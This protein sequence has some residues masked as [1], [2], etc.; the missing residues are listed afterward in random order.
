GALHMGFWGFLQAKNGGKACTEL[1]GLGGKGEGKEYVK[2]LAEDGLV[3]LE[4]VNPL[5]SREVIGVDK[6]KEWLR[7]TFVGEKLPI[8][9]ILGVNRAPSEIVRIEIGI[10]E[11]G[12]RLLV[13]VEREKED[14]DEFMDQPNPTFS[15]IPILDTGKFEQWKFRIQ[16]YL[17]NEHYAL[18]KVIEFG[19]SYKAPPEETS[20]GPASES[21]T[22]KKGRTVVITIEDM[23]KRRNDVKA[24]TTLLLAL[25]NEHQLR[26]SK[27]ETAQELWEAILN[28]FGGNEATKKTKKNQLKQQY[29]NFKA[30]G[31][32]TLEQTFKRLQ[33]IM[34]H[35]EFMDV[36][37]EQDD[38]NQKF[39]TSLA[40]EW[41]MYTIVWRNR[42]DLDTMSLDDGYNH[43]KVYEPEV[44]KKLE[45]TSQNMAFIS[46]SNTSNGKGEVHTA[47]VPT[48][49]IHVSTVSTDIDK[50]YIEEI[51]IKW[52]MDLLSMR[53]DRFWKKTGKKINIQ[54]SD[55]AGFDKSKVKCFICHKIG[56]FAKECRAPRSQDR[57]KRESYKQGPK[58][59][60]P[61]PKALMALDGIGVI[62]LMR[63]RTMLLKNIKNLNTK[64]SKLNKQL[65]DC[66]TD[67]YHYK[68]GLSQ[69][70]ARLV[71]FKEQEIK[72]CEK[73]RG[74]ERYVEVRNNKNKYLMNELEQVKKEKEGL[75]NKL[76]SFESASK[77]L[78][79]LLGSQRSDK[80]K[81][82]LGYNAVP[83]PH[84]QVYSPPKKDLSW[85][86]LPKFID[87]NVTDYSRPTPSI[88]ESKCN[89]SNNFSISK[90][91]ES[92]G[93]IM[94][95]PMIKFVKAADCPKVTKTNNTENARKSTV[96]HTKM[97][98]NTSKSPKVGGET[99][100]KNNY[101]HKNVTPRAVL[102]KTGRTPLAIS[103][104]NMNVAQPKM[105][106]FAKIAHSNVKRHFQGKSAVRTQP[107]VLRVSTFTKKFPTVDSK[108]PIVKSTFTADL[109]NKGKGNIDDK[110]YWDSGCSRHMTDNIS[111]LSEYE[112]Y[113]GGYVSFGQGG[114][115]I[116]GK[117]I[118]KTGKL[119]F[120]NVYFVKELKYFKLKDDTNVLL[121]TP[122]QHNMYS[123]DLNNI[124]PYKNL[125][126]LVAKASI[127]ESMLWHRRLGHLNFKTMNKLVRNNLV[128]GLPSKCFENDHTC[129][130]CLKGKQHK[131][132][133]KTKLVNFVSKPIHTLHMDLFGPTSAEAVNTACYVK[134]RVLVNKSQNKT[135]YELFNSRIPAIVFL[136]PFGCHVMILNTLDHLGKFDAKEDEG[137]FVGYSMSSKAF[138]V[139]NKRTK[140]VEEN[141]HVDFLENK[142]ITKGVGSNWLFDIDTLT[143][144]MNYVS[145][146]VAG[147]SSTNISGTKDVASQAMKKDV[148]SLRYIALLNWFHDTHMETK[149]SDGC[150]TDDPESSGISNPTTS[151]K[152]PSAEQVEH[153]VSLTVETK[154]PTVSSPVPTVCLDIS[155]ESSS[156]P[157]II[158]KGDFSQKETPSLGNALTLSN[159]F[160]DAFR[161]EADLS[162][163]ETSIPV[164]PTSTFEIHKG[165]PKSQIIGPVDSSVQTRHK[166]KEM[167]EQSFIVTIHHKTN[168]ELLQFCLFLC[169]LSQ[170]EPKKIFDDLKDPSW[171]EGIDYE[172]VFA[173]VVRIKAIRLFLAYAS[174]M[175]FI[176]YQMD[177]KSA[178]LYGTIDEEGEGSTIPTEPHHTPSPQE[179]HSPHHA[180]SSLSH[181]TTTTEPLPQTPTE[182]PTETPTLR[183]YTRRDI[184]IAQSK[185]LSPDADEPASLLR[186]D[187]Q[188]EA[189]PT[190]S[191]LDARQD[192][193]NI[194][195]TSVLPHGSSPR[196]TSLDADEGSMQHRLQKLMELCTSLQ[197]QQ[198]Q[199]AAKIKDQD[200]EI[201]G[202][203]ARVK[204]LEDKDRG[205]AEPTQVD[206]PIKG[207]IME[208]G[209]E[210]RADK[211]TELGSNDTDEMVNV[212]SLMEAANILTSGV[213]AVSVSPVAGVS[214]KGVPTVSGLFPT[215]SAIFTTASVVTPYTRR[216][217]RIL[218][219]DKDKEKVMEFEVPN[220]RKLEEQI[221]AQVAR[222]MKEE[223]TRENQRESEQ[224]T[225]DSEIARLHAEEEIKMMIE[226]LNR[227]N[228]VIAKHLQEYEEAAAEL[229][230]G[231]K[232]ELI[233]ELVKYQDHHTK[234]LK[235][236]AH[237][238]KP[239][240]KK[241]QREFCMSVLRSH[242]GW[243]TKH[244]RGMTLKEIKEKFIPVWKQ[245]EDFVPMSSKEE[246][247]K[248]MM[249]LVPLEEVYVEVLQVKHPIIDWE[250]NS[251]EKREPATK[252]NEKE[253]WVELK[254]LFEPDFEDRLWTHNQ[255]LMHDP[256]EWK[257]YDTYGI[258]HVFFKDQEIF[259]LV[260]KDY[261]LRKG[262][263]TVM[264]CNKLQ[265][266]QYSQMD[267][268]L[269]LKIHNIANSPR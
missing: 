218:A 145:V 87:D 230:V 191:S 207:G 211:S 111:Y 22:K 141:L 30:E 144:S 77:N 2:K 51:D 174:F 98:R 86:G 261:P 43:L 212:L 110:G 250:I 75:D 168:P 157:R 225:R 69:V 117:G 237:Q 108:F 216:S 17:Q 8:N 181:P 54:G 61:A 112:P 142:L 188:R 5:W 189:F 15:K 56:H 58:E 44:Q 140:K 68:R 269:I 28:T 266:E 262:L 104:P 136:R 242:V 194:N 209:E 198:T 34:S 53:A 134:N 135:P 185:A 65:S 130:A 129:V 38:L 210:V 126:C 200:L 72:F 255:A 74:L 199:M 228:E 85:T 238:S 114:G 13:V 42:D 170:E 149:N 265:V 229:S 183:R 36:E 46:S 71:E 241:E 122:R 182:T 220:K 247:L 57:G 37:I 249:Q 226:G 101:A 10:D 41:L 60:E 166:S 217:R 89:T 133:H 6:V 235:Y 124:V 66:E 192:R 48:A 208:T 259:M 260:E 151:S 119:E 137:Y 123:I 9:N 219:K 39:L 40:P 171:E 78:D 16:Q 240:L 227:S 49:S 244:F 4:K 52:N 179:Q 176:V 83:P 11:C 201:F 147:T 263:A 45:L 131:A 254:R 197:R 26:F 155:L 224:L 243:K 62:W 103:R 115:T 214:T 177:V 193:E 55:V 105:T 256:L 164:S 159:R 70:E 138:R 106:S 99:W 196:V 205:S 195:K 257:L 160:K 50:D 156:D 221:D 184:R 121:R 14:C 233:N 32:E 64:I 23:Q 248:G 12:C 132:S 91:R 73:L 125:T 163:M 206:A 90:H 127:N 158:S 18:W 252:D 162:N 251:E 82:G 204:F 35:L 236:H 234:I 128:R 172:E 187:R 143:N 268:D 113:D 25:P 190:V 118:I 180:L 63:K 223:F 81:E 146:V 94:S 95:K 20:K 102:L 116:T 239:L 246:D 222:E 97:Y 178:F 27:Y 120:E 167:E 154:I 169:F 84:A 80:N 29:G 152:V 150:N 79:T 267:N 24:R 148:S 253:L 173:P 139:F 96:K 7:K 67:L 232:I 258:H 47:S 31:S 186:D 153:A 264:I 59:E 76:T 161:E 165:H 100:P 1:G 213:A 109:G 245:L 3:D 202:L 92:L 231:E 33:A 88:D 175:G 203:K 93:S 19:N 215:A 21:S 107:R